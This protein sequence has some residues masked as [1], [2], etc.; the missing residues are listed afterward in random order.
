M[1][2]STDRTREQNKITV[3]HQ[4]CPGGVYGIQLLSKLTND[5]GATAS[6]LVDI[7]RP[8]LSVLVDR[9]HPASDTHC[10]DLQ[11]TTTT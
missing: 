6:S 2:F 3:C 5:E 8:D 1:V 10:I 11:T 7:W 9:P 4:L